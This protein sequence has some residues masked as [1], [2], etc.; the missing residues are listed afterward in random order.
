MASRRILPDTV[1][2]YNYAGEVN[3]EAVFQETILTHCYCPIN[4]GADLNMQGR[5]ANN[6]GSLYIFDAITTAKGSDG[7][8]RTYLPYREWIE[9]DDKS[10]FWTISDLGYDYFV[11]HGSEAKLRITGFSHKVNGTRRMHHFEVNG[12]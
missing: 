2:L 10:R 3:D 4:E 1:V 8:I 11:K 9:L 7:S 12:A 5:K 6:S